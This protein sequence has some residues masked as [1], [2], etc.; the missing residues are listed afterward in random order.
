ML[1]VSKE[2]GK[3]IV[4]IQPFN[5]LYSM[6]KKKICPFHNFIILARFF[7]FF[8]A[9]ILSIFFFFVIVWFPNQVMFSLILIP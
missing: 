4:N 5:L 8:L 7:V 3:F 9:L 1:R 2:Q 6:I